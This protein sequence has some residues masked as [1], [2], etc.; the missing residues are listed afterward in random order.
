MAGGMAYPRKPLRK[1][2]NEYR[3]QQRGCPGV[4]TEKHL[5]RHHRRDRQ[6]LEIVRLDNCYTTDNKLT[7]PGTYFQGGQQGVGL[8][9]GVWGM[10]SAH[11]A[12]GWKNGPEGKASKF[13]VPRDW[14]LMWVM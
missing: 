7:G 6:C 12:W 9:N 8:E 13:Q 14:R 1:Q 10:L 4:K 3:E 2:T 11:L 5:K